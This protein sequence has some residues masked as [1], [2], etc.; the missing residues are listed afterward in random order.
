MKLLPKIS[1]TLLSFFLVFIVYPNITQAAESI[2]PGFPADNQPKTFSDYGKEF[3]DKRSGELMNLETWFSGK[4]GK[5]V[6]TFSGEG[7]GFSD[8]VMLQI[9]EYVNGPQ[10]EDFIG[11]IS[12]YVKALQEAAKLVEVNNQLNTADI[13]R[14]FGN[15]GG[16][17]SS[18][19][20][21]TGLII[22]TKPATLNGYA[23]HVANNLK[24][25]QI[26]TNTYAAGSP[27]QGFKALEP[28]LPIWKAFRNLA[29]MLFAIAFIMYGVMIMFRVRVDSKTAATIQLAI[30]KLV[31]TLLLITFSYAIVGLLIDLS[32]VFTAMAVNILRVPGAILKETGPIPL[33]NLASGHGGAVNSLVVNS[34]AAWIVTPF[35]IFNVLIGGS[36]GVIIATILNYAF[37]WNLGLIVF[38]FILLAVMYALFKL[39]L[40]LFQAFFNVIINLIFSPLI[41]LGDVFPG[42]KAAGSWFRN[43]IG[44]LA[45]FPA[46]IFLLTLSY[47]LM[48]QPLLNLNTLFAGGVLSSILNNINLEDLLGV[49]NLSNM[50]NIWT[51]PLTIGTVAG[52][53]GQDNQAVGSVML[54]MIGVGLLLMASKYVDMV[55]DAF[56]VEQFKYGSAIGDALKYPIQVGKSAINLGK[57]IVKLGAGIP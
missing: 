29:Y 49:K 5:D 26:V 8:I 32:T 6:D 27:V 34:V 11:T 46:A 31:S 56:K 20:T 25:H 7:V 18:A 28:I 43:M 19:T 33:V 39:I 37:M 13:N 22:E 57:G 50:N 41:L 36:T 51:P 12:K 14:I 48:V 21:I 3:C 44:N 15:S 4:C 55:N 40:K 2:F 54:A 1:T 45:T 10:T 53:V 17:I 52:G 42:S 47:A 23:S 9:F 16:L 35:I 30:P 24:R 38:I